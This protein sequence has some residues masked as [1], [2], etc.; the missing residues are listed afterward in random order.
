MYATPVA[1]RLY[2]KHFI[3]AC[4]S[5]AVRIEQCVVLNTLPLTKKC[6]HSLHCSYVSLKLLLCTAY[7]ERTQDLAVWWCYSTATT[8]TTIAAP[9]TGTTT[10]TD[11]TTTELLLLLPY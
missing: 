4:V 2:T 11:N 8:A 3:C 10:T 1:A 7:A 6:Q 9:Y 5:H